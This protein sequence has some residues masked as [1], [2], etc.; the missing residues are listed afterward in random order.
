L[1]LLIQSLTFGEKK[2]IEGALQ[3]SFPI[4]GRYEPFA[5]PNWATKYLIDALIIEK[6]LK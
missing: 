1:L 5:F 3:G 6:E 4:W 2:E